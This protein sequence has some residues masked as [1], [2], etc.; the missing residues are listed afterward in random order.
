MIKGN[1]T[2]CIQL[3]HILDIQ[4]TYSSIIHDPITHEAIDQKI[5]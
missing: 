3:Y 4:I 5:I 1:K 2:N